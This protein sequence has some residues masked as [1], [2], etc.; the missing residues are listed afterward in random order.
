MGDWVHYN[1]AKLI[2][3]QK[4]AKARSNAGEFGIAG[5]EYFDNFYK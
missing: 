5:K 4:A 1:W 2:W 3:G